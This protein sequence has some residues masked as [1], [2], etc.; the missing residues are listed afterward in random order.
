MLVRTSHSCWLLIALICLSACPSDPA[1]FAP[2]GLVNMVELASVTVSPAP[3]APDPVN[4]ILTFCA[5]VNAEGRQLTGTIDISLVDEVA[6]GPFSINV[7]GAGGIVYEYEGEFMSFVDVDEMDVVGNI[8]VDVYVESCDVEDVSFSIRVQSLDRMAEQQ[9]QV[10]NAGT[11][12]S[13]PG[14]PG[15]S[16]VVYESSKV[17]YVV[18]LDNTNQRV[19]NPVQLTAGSKPAM[20]P[21]GTR[22]AF[23]RG[24]DVWVIDV[25]GA[26]L[27]QLTS[28]PGKEEEHA[29]WS[30]DGQW[31]AFDREADGE[32]NRDLWVVAANGLA[33]RQITSTPDLDH[34]PDWSPDGTK[35]LFTRSENLFWIPVDQANPTP[36]SRD[37]EPVSSDPSILERGGRW[38]PDGTRIAFTR[39]DGLDLSGSIWIVDVDPTDGT[40]DTATA[41]RITPEDNNSYKDLAWS[42]DGESLVFSGEPKGT[43]DSSLYVAEVANPGSVVRLDLGVGAEKAHWGP[44]PE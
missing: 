1:R 34:R 44:S 22:I 9:F 25:T 16:F 13:P 30:P 41:E 12:P 42:P 17:L 36:P 18:G 38:S 39:L 23:T 10:Q 20:S 29:A 19:G 33:S 4:D 31:I 27:N 8:T 21:D 11:P 5:D 15:A 3:G 26:N 14:N 6:A 35:M 28:T 32:G 7:L 37:P 24:G 43:K 40:A 2:A